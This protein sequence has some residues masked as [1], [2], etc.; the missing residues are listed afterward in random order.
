VIK[1]IFSEDFHGT[2]GPTLPIGKLAMQYAVIFGLDFVARE[3]LKLIVYVLF[4]EHDFLSP[5]HSLNAFEFKLF[6]SENIL[7]FESI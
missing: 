5:T 2:F 4:L 3:I 6:N 1:C 7:V